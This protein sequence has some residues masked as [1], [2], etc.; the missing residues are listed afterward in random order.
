MPDEFWSMTFAEVEIAC[1]GYETR[2]ARL[3]EV[4][5]L[6]AAIL[7]N[8]NRKKGSAP[9]RVENVFPL[10]TDGRNKVELMTK[11]EFENLK[12]LRKSIV[13]RTKDLRRN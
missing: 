6:V 9:I 5:R 7:L 10:Y 12:E 3:K 1:K 2:M 11:E 8:V 4:P 13:W